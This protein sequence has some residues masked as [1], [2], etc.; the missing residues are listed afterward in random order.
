MDKISNVA[1][2]THASP[3]FT[4]LDSAGNARLSGSVSKALPSRETADNQPQ[5]EAGK[6]SI[7]EAVNRIEKI[8]AATNSEIKFS[9]DAETGIDVVKVIDKATDK[10]IRQIPSEE[11]IAIAKTLDKLQGLLF[12]GKA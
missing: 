3:H 5:S 12:K 4:T 9:V 7:H 11:M 2:Q 10:V 1:A 8:V 6:I